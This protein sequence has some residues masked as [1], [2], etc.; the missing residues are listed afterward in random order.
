MF[1]T[2]RRLGIRDRDLEDVTHDVFVVVHRKLDDYDASRPLRPWLFGIAHRVAADYRRLA[3][4]RRE[5][6]DEQTDRI[7]SPRADVEAD[8]QKR[9]ARTIVLAALDQLEPQRRAV[10][11]MHEID[12]FSMPEIAE[13]LNIPLNTGY[14]RLRLAREGF[15][16][17]VAA[18]Q[19]NARRDQGGER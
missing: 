4:H 19:A 11:A 9:E 3:R 8:A 12:G 16:A 17:A 15:A 10:F 7:P 6:F 5:V 1:H 13:A 18:V 14:S 2:L